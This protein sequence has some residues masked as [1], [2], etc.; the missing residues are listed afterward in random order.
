MSH[1]SQILRLQNKKRILKTTKEKHHLTY[2]G[3]SFGI[4]SHFSAGNL[5]GQENIEGMR[6]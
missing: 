2:K 1:Y 5:K 6:D 4:K 3:E